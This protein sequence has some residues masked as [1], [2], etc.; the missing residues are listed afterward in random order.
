MT[1]A[2]FL[3]NEDAADADILKKMVVDACIK[4]GVPEALDK[5]LV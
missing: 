4:I 1:P 3:G 2:D 5:S